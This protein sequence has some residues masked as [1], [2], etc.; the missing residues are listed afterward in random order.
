MY[1]GVIFDFGNTLASSSSLQQSLVQ[2]FTDDRAA[3]I[4]AS[5]EKKILA[6]YRPQQRIQPGWQELWREAFS[7]Q[8]CQYQ[9][10]IARAHLQQ[11][12]NNNVTFE[13]S[14]G[15]LKTL[16]A[17]GKKLVLL[18]N[19]TGPVEIFN[20]DLVQRGL[21]KY[22]DAVIW[23]SQIGCRK[24]APAAFAAALSALALPKN[25]VLMV[26]DSEVA[27]VLGAQQI[28]IDS[29]RLWSKVEPVQSRANYLV[30]QENARQEILSIVG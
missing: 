10:T 14:Q 5:I 30:S 18:S 28:G 16:K 11:F 13:F 6:L 1:K 23:S 8:N 26:G 4:G 22:F 15:L 24:P 19:V 2:V 29:A 17:R 21:A 20:D 27:D 7:E 9:E 3:V 25:E 12:A